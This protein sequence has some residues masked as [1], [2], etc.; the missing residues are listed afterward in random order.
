MTVVSLNAHAERRR[1]RAMLSDIATQSVMLEYPGYAI[2]AIEAGIAA[3]NEVIANGGTLAEALLAARPAVLHNA[4]T[5]NATRLAEFYARRE[6][7]TRI[8]LETIEGI[9]RKTLT[10]QEITEALARAKRVLDGGGSAWLA[11]VRSYER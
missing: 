2:A 5:R 6:Q 8:R 4:G 1:S 3:A 9:L 11:L 10:E 7:R